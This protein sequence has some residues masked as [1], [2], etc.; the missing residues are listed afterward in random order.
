MSTSAPLVDKDPGIDQRPRGEAMASELPGEFI[1]TTNGRR[2][3]TIILSVL[4]L[5]FLLNL[6]VTVWLNKTVPNEGYRKIRQKW[7]MLEHLQKPV[8]TVILGDSSGAQ[9]FDPEVVTMNLGGS[10]INLCTVGDMTV[11]D[12]AAML[13][14]YVRKYGPPKRVIVVH[15]FDVWNRQITGYAFAQ[16]PLKPSS[17]AVAWWPRAKDPAL[18][19]EMFLGRNVKL[20]S[21]SKSLLEDV[22]ELVKGHKNRGPGPRPDGFSVALKPDRNQLNRDVKEHLDTA[23]QIDPS[24]SAD[25]VAALKHMGDLSKRYGFPV[26]I[27]NGPISDLVMSDPTFVGAYRK[28]IDNVAQECA[29]DGEIF[30]MQTPMQ[31]PRGEMDNVDH[32]TYAGA[33]KYTQAAVQCMESNT[34]GR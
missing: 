8:D 33:Q 2:V 24:I 12:S 21:E 18:Q 29:R 30:L 28:T 5:V 20:F 9:G 15:V 23:A 11:V 1:P 22:K 34:V 6:V 4:A 27:V 3:G 26:Y 16:T 10:A 17:P 19:R 31:F 32:L 25:N 7:S 13:D 14:E